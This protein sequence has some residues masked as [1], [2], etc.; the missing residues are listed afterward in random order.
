MLSRANPGADYYN[1]HTKATTWYTP[2]KDKPPPP[3]PP[4]RPSGQ[5]SARSHRASKS[6]PQMRRTS[7]RSSSVAM[8]VINNTS[9][10][11][12]VSE[13]IAA[14]QTKRK[15]VEA[16]Q[17]ECQRGHDQRGLETVSL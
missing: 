6:S 12:A 5:E 14:M 15:M 13:V 1:V 17:S 7:R 10:G 2:R 16:V 8:E 3:P 11:H 9:Q 4:R